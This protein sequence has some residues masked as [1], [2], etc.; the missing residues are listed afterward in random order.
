MKMIAKRSH[1]YTVFVE[2]LPR[3][4]SGHLQFL[5]C[6]LC[7]RLAM[8]KTRKLN[9]NRLEACFAMKPSCVYFV[10]VSAL[11]VSS[12]SMLLN[13][14]DCHR[15]FLFTMKLGRKNHMCPKYFLVPLTNLCL[16]NINHH[17]AYLCS[18]WL[19]GVCIKAQNDVLNL[20]AIYVE[21]R[22]IHSL[23]GTIHHFSTI[24][25]IK[26]STKS[27]HKYILYHEYI[28]ILFTTSDPFIPLATYRT[29]SNLRR[30]A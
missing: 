12:E 11:T 7:H 28:N 8:Q 27:M 13:F 9:V 17:Y 1:I 23:V 3:V 22:P 24:V 25:Y 6:H 18:M 20:H 16:N 26:L 10:E 29:L 30:S 19:C 21:K 5:L 4:V 15:C 2:K 14:L